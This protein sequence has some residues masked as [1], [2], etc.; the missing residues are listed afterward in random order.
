MTVSTQAQLVSAVRTALDPSSGPILLE[1]GLQ[2]ATKVCA[3]DGNG[4]PSFKVSKK[5]FIHIDFI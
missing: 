1:A 4:F 2:L 5:L 3:V